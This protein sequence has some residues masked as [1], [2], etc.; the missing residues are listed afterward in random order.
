[1]SLD[2]DVYPLFSTPLYKTNLGRDDT[3]ILDFTK[4]EKFPFSEHIT[5]GYVSSNVYVLENDVLIELKS[6]LQNNINFFAYEVLGVS[7]QIQFYIT[8]SWIMK[9]EPENWAQQHFHNNSLLTGIYYF[10]VSE[11][12][13]AITFSKDRSITNTLPP[14]FDFSYSKET[15][16]NTKSMNIIPKNGDLI[17]FPSHLLHSVDHNKSEKDRYC[18]AF[19]VFIK[20][21]L[22]NDYSFNRLDFK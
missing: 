12:S 1:M 10:D 6:A 22:G 16:F 20:G 18:L 19:N 2:V 9:H 4:N 15:T 5:N 11:N 21:T 8:N 17:L 14:M 13:G 3:D 7:N